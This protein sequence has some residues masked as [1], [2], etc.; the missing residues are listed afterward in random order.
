MVID[1]EY[2]LDQWFVQQFSEPVQDHCVFL[3][4][5]IPENYLLQIFAMDLS[6]LDSIVHSTVSHLQNKSKYTQILTKP[7]IGI[8]IPYD[9]HNPSVPM[10]P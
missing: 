4:E 2:D 6:H 7:G 9:L 5:E 3:K 1:L 8:N 10:N